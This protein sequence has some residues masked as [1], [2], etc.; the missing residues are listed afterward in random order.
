[1]L[2]VEDPAGTPDPFLRAGQAAVRTILGEVA[3]RPSK[4]I[5]AAEVRTDARFLENPERCA[6]VMFHVLNCFPD[7]NT[8]LLTYQI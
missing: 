5:R 7:S 3:N 8:G 4:G 1:M 6:E 2:S